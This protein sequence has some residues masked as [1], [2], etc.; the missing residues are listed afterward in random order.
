MFKY[1]SI[2]YEKVKKS[3]QNMT[4]FNIILF[5]YV[6]LINYNITYYIYFMIYDIS[7]ASSVTT[8]FV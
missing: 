2:Y 3:L 8:T 6:F 1:T 4:L 7:S 5:Y